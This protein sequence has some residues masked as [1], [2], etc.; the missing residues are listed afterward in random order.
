MEKMKG[1]LITGNIKD[2]VEIVLVIVIIMI[3]L[4]WAGLGMSDLIGFVGTGI[5][6]LYNW[7]TGL[8]GF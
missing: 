3:L 6:E 4:Q 7:F 8:F 5:T 2:I 1:A